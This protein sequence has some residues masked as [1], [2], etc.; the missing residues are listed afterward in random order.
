MNMHCS[1]ALDMFLLFLSM[2]I[3]NV[4]A[5]LHQRN[6][7]ARDQSPGVSRR[8]S[9]EVIE[10]VPD[11]PSPT[12]P[13]IL[14]ATLSRGVNPLGPNPVRPQH[15]PKTNQSGRKTTWQT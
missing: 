2:R 10:L 9:K 8:A 12:A 3:F 13:P 14:R 4:I 11:V 1:E 7:T 5:I 15:R 6:L